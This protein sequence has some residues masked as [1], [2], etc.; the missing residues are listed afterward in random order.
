LATVAIGLAATGLF[1]TGSKAVNGNIAPSAIEI[2]TPNRANLYPGNAS[3]SSCSPLGTGVDW[4]KDCDDNDDAPTLINTVATGIDPG[5]TGTAAREGHWNGVRLVD[6]VAGSDEDIFLTGGKEN[7]VSTW[8]VGPGSI[9]SSKYDATQAYLAN[10]Q[11]FLFFGMERRGNN[12]TTAFD[13]EFNQNAPPAGLG[14]YIPNRTE[15]DVLLTFELQGSGGSG[16][17]SA[18]YF[19]WNGSAYVEQDLPD[20]VVT[21]INDST[22]TPAAPW[23][24]VDSKGKWVGGNLSRFEFGEAQVPLSILP[25]VDNCGG[26]AFVQ[27]RTR[28]SST[29]TSDLKDA[30]K[31]FDFQFGSPDADQTLAT[32]CTQQ[33]TYDGSGSAGSSG[34]TG[35]TYAWDIS[36]DPAVATL[37]G[38]VT[39]TNTA[40][41]YTSDKA[42]GTVNVTLLSGASSAAVSVKNTIDDSGCAD[43][44]GTKTVTVYRELGAVATLTAQCDNKFSYSA[45]A[46]GGLAP[47]SYSWKFQRNSA[48]D[49]SG[50]WQDAGTSTSQSGTFTAST[51]GA[52]RGLLTVKDTAATSSDG[53]VTPKP[54]C[55]KEVTSNTV[56]VYDAVTGSITLTG[57]CDDTFAYAALGGGGK[58]PYTYDVT[59]EKLVSGVWTTAKTFSASDTVASPGISGTLDVD[60]FAT[61]AKGDGTYRARVTIT[62]S[63]GLVCTANATSNSIEVL[64]ALTA[65]AA[66]T[67]AD[68]TTL[69]ANLAGTTAG[70]SV[71]WQRLS[72]GTWVNISGATAA[73]FGYSSFEADTT[74]VPTTFTIASGNA[75]GAYA[76]KLYSVSLRIKASRV[77]N[78]ITCE[79]TSSA[80]VVKKVVAVDP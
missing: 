25:G 18:H 42:K 29:S 33:F 63:Q 19:Q 77:V 36:V 22:T 57:D 40:G 37:A 78:G 14:T 61:G 39:A 65:S 30:S 74:S 28:S 4:V 41:K 56:N 8:N 16:S 68:G 43:A 69:T 80:V 2:D 70:T 38:D 52:Y 3:T 9:G 55:S 64:H 31:I 76:G 79:T 44:T 60:D 54:Q 53:A 47:Y 49:G 35:V 71:Q 20:G 12:G 24:H 11:D 6:G 46:S 5:V 59:V 7:D 27:L 67:G 50:T 72:G 21:S 1:P 32:N 15:D 13:F 66:K 34:S 73:T 23:G 45:T 75:S 17:A 51:S 62:D 26:E 48:P 58:A 10:N